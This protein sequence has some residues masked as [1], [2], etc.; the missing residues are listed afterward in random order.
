MKKEKIETI[1]LHINFTK[2]QMYVFSFQSN[3]Q[4]TRA[5][6]ADVVNSTN[7]ELHYSFLIVKQMSINSLVHC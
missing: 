3:L 1:G 7:V 5:I 6:S 4:Y 2:N